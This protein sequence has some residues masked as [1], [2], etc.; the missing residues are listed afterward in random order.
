MN[1]TPKPFVV[2]TEAGT[3][4]SDHD[5]IEQAQAAA[6]QCNAKAEALEIEARYKAEAR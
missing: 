2:R 4:R 5:T 1:T 3:F 6:Q